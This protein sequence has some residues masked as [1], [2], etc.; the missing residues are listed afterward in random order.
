MTNNSLSF[1]HDTE[2]SALCDVAPTMLDA[3][4]IEI[5][6]EMTGRSLLKK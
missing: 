1:V 6:K 3:M 2:S 5:P 4:G